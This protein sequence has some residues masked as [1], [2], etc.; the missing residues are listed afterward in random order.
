MKV[1]KLDSSPQEISLSVK[2]S[3]IGALYIIQHEALKNPDINFA[4]VMVKHP[5]TKECWMR[6]SA[7]GDRAAGAVLDAADAALENIRNLG[8]MLESTLRNPQT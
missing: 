8:G 6:V 1:E 2:E 7:D 3:D 4:G 5:L